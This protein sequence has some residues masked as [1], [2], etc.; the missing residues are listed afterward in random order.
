MIVLSTQKVM[1]L[2]QFLMQE[3]GGL[4]GIR[5]EGLFDS[6][7]QGPF[8]TFG[9]QELYPSIE[10]KA[11]KLGV[12]L[13]KNHAFLDGNKRIG[14]YALLVFLDVNG[15]A[16]E[17]SDADLISLGL[18]MADGTLDYEDVLGWIHKHKT[19]ELSQPNPT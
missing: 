7:V 3:T 9:G 19:G 17:Y 16:M 10:E 14:A 5:D 1:Q 6:A 4:D 18:G 2:H 15:V 12:T 11:A 13:T 8:A